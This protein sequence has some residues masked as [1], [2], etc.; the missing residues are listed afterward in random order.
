MLLDPCPSRPLIDTHYRSA[1]R[2]LNFLG[3]TCRVYKQ[4]GS[5]LGRELVL[6]QQPANDFRS[7][8]SGRDYLIY[9][10]GTPVATR[11]HGMVMLVGCQALPDQFYKIALAV[12]PPNS[13]E[14]G[15]TMT[16][17]AWKVRIF[18]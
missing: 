16:P 3:Y 1:A 17:L 11:C 14:A 9:K 5:G 8:E 6:T 13:G 15:N 4:W 18:S 2:R 12:V 10:H 7:N